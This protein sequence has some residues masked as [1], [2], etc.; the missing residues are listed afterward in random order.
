M[1]DEAAA[2]YSAPDAT[3]STV[4]GATAELEFSTSE[5]YMLTA[6][7]SDVPVSGDAGATLRL[8]EEVARGSE[9]GERRADTKRRSDRRRRPPKSRGCHQVARKAASRRP[10]DGATGTS[11]PRVVISKTPNAADADSGATC[12]EQFGTAARQP[13][14]RASRDTAAAPPTLGFACGTCEKVF[15]DAA[16]LRRHG[17]VHESSGLTCAT[18]GKTLKNELTLRKHA[19]TH[20][21]A[22]H[23]CATCGKAFRSPASLRAHATRH[24]PEGSPHKC[25]VCGRDCRT[26]DYLRAHLRDAHGPPAKRHQCVTC[27][28]F[29]K[30]GKTLEVHAATQHGV[31][32]GVD[33]MPACDVCGKRF[34]H[35]SVL[36]VHAAKHDERRPHACA[37]CAAAFKTAV[38]LASHARVVHSAARDHACRE[39][40]KAFKTRTYLSAHVASVHAGGVADAWRCRRCPK[41]FKCK[42]SLAAHEVRHGDAP[43]HYCAY[44]ARGFM[45]CRRT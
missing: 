24:L 39:C 29:Y 13:G 32:A 42:R 31:G 36:A 30:Y 8:D 27:G 35:R 38:A 4:G 40:G 44:C 19:R 34:A 45:S 9:A 6:P 10:A 1:A 21:A 17:Y 12:G 25:V 15:G 22:R 33:A 23:V 37:E 28:K 20:A 18:C 3:T 7:S 14:G 5:S 2:S 16:G 41:A 26:S 43:R 11:T